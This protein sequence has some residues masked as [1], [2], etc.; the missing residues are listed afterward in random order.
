MKPSVAVWRVVWECQVVGA[1]AIFIFWGPP[2]G[3]VREASRAGSSSNPVAQAFSV[4]PASLGNIV[5][6]IQVYLGILMYI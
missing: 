4:Q 1:Q 3:L 6:D 2:L 5:I